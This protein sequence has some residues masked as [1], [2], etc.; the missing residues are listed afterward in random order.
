MNVADKTPVLSTLNWIIEPLEW[1]VALS[2]ALRKG[3]H[4]RLLQIG[5]QEIESAMVDLNL[6]NTHELCRVCEAFSGRIINSEQ[7]YPTK[8]GNWGRCKCI[9]LQRS[10]VHKFP[11]L[12]R[13]VFY[14]SHR[15]YFSRKACCTFSLREFFE[16]DR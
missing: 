14:V 6:E 10:S 12:K 8:G 16:L 9:F 1:P 4:R 11:Y 7:S 15:N 2:R 3:K 5:E 13:K